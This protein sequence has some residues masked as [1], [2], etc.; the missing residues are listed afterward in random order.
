MVY[1]DPGFDQCQL[2][3]V[4][5]EA[6]LDQAVGPGVGSGL[7]LDPHTAMVVVWPG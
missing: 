4:G 2:L 1:N 3:H 6:V 5:G 7:E